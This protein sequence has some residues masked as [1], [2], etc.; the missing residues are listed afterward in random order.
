MSFYKLD[1]DLHEGSN[2]IFGPDYLLLSE[3]KDEYNLPIDGWY[4]FDTPEEAYE[5]FKYI[6]P[7]IE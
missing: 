7:V 3:H 4:W 2:F 6:P 5:F 1:V